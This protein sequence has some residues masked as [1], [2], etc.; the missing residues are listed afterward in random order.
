MELQQLRY[1]LVVATEQHISRAADK[2]HIAQPALTQCIH[3]LEDELG[4][5]L[6]DRVGRNI[7]LNK[8]GLLL[9]K[10]VMPIIAA[11][12]HIP[13]EFN[14]IKEKK[15][16]SVK[17]DIAAGSEIMSR[18][19]IEY[20]DM[21]PEVAFHLMQNVH[22]NESDITVSAIPFDDIQTATDAIFQEEIFLAVPLTSKFATRDSVRL[23]EL[24]TERFIVLAGS[25]PLRNIC[26]KLCN[27]VGFEPNIVFES[28]SPMM[29]RNLIEAG[30]GIGF[31]PSF[32][33]GKFE[34]V[35]AILIPIGSPHCARNLV[36]KLNRNVMDKSICRDFYEYTISYLIRATSNK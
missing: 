12:E 34:S 28:D 29:V 9:Q 10:R 25:K 32:S 26:D 19:L 11:L 31:W 4:I 16:F 5:L 36:V 15:N 14:A 23:D 21:H 2:L 24:Q 20:Q 22:E 1:F 17:L 13:L 7:K 27:S 8:N 30:I 6:F 18:I 3:R 33:W 35:K